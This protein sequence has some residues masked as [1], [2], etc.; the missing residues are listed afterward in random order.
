MDTEQSHI[1]LVDNCAFLS[2][3]C[4]LQRIEHVFLARSIQRNLRSKIPDSVK[5]K[6]V[7]MIDLKH[8]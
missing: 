3:N 8:F 5:Q 4:A 1:A 6:C 2:G 7:K